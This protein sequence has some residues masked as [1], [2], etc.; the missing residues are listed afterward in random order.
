MAIVSIVAA[1]IAC[2][3]AGAA[4]YAVASLRRTTRTLEDE[5]ERGKA[6][7]DEIVAEEAEIRAVEL[8]QAL[9]IARS[10][11]L[12]VLGEEERRITEERR[13]DVAERERDA[14][15]KLIASLTAAQRSVEQRFADWGADV[16]T[17]QQSLTAELE[18]VGQRQQQLIAGVEAKIEK[19]TDRFEAALDD[20]KGRVTRTREELERELQDL[21]TAFA[22]DLEAHAA[23]RRRA[24]HEVAERLRRRE[25]E[26]QEQIDREQADATQRV[27]TALKDVERRQ[28]EQLQR[29]VSRETQHA[30]EA[31]ATQ[32]DETIR[33]SREDAARRLAREVELSV[34]RFARQAEGPIAE[35]IDSELRA[36]ESRIAELTRRLESLSAHS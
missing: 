4:F 16:T 36:V 24:L 7:F 8:E 33:K 11:A 25:R 3:A 21:A 28:L 31:V 22:A 18:R 13:R 23:E 30:A 17:L 32:F 9:T 34:E 19:E 6:R 5:I 27:G 20:H 29:V 10:Q 35:R 1:V 15:A 14:T 26:L 12:S 2:A